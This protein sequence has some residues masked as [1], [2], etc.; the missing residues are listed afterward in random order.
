MPLAYGANHSRYDSLPLSL[1]CFCTSVPSVLAAPYL[2]PLLSPNPRAIGSLL[3]LLPCVLVCT[4]CLFRTVYALY[5]LLLTCWVAV[6]Y[7]H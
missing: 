2:V 5:N 3:T 7:D 1:C 4:I 6:P